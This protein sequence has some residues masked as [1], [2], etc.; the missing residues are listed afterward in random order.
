[1]NGKQPKSRLTRLPDK[2]LIVSTCTVS[3]CADLISR[4]QICSPIDKME[5]EWSVRSR[6]NA[7]GFVRET[8]LYGFVIFVLLAC[9]RW[10][11]HP[12]FASN[13]FEIWAVSTIVL[14][15]LLWAGKRLL[16]D[17]FKW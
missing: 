17:A 11:W 13:L 8:L 1:M 7:W 9:I 3:G 6:K 15:P 16:T 5:P 4:M 10:V 12:S 2:W 14:A